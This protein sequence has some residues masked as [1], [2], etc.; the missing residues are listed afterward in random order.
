MNFAS[1][2]LMLLA[3]SIAPIPSHAI[4]PFWK[5]TTTTTNI[6][7]ISPAQRKR[8]EAEIEAAKLQKFINNVGQSLFGIMAVGATT[9][10]LLS[11]HSLCTDGIPM[12]N[13]SITGQKVPNYEPVAIALASASIA[14]GAAYGIKELHDEHSEI[15]QRMNSLKKS[16]SQ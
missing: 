10:F 1:Q 5:K 9:V 12:E 11:A 16:L 13:S 7:Y 4:I 2:V 15:V 3:L 8:I 14:G 6:P